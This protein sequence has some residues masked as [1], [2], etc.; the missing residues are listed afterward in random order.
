M[1]SKRL[2]FQSLAECGQRLSRRDIRRQV[3]LHTCSNNNYGSDEF[4]SSNLRLLRRLLMRKMTTARHSR[5]RITATTDSPTATPTADDSRPPTLPTDTHY[6]HQWHAI[7][8]VSVPISHALTDN[9]CPSMRKCAD[10]TCVYF[11]RNVLNENK[12]KLLH[13]NRRSLLVIP[14]GKQNTR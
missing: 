5:T 1:T 2:C 3:V 4:F 13:Y 8:P 14:T 7:N 6:T 11:G 9:R 10:M 12:K